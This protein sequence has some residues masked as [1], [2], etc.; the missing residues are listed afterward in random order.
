MS[1][2]YI[3]WFF[4]NHSFISWSSLSYVAGDSAN[5]DSILNRQ[6]VIWLDIL[7]DIEEIGSLLLLIPKDAD[8]NWEFCWV[9]NEASSVWFEFI[10]LKLGF[11]L[12]VSLWPQSLAIVLENISFRLLWLVSEICCWFLENL[13]LKFVFRLTLAF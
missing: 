11:E 12:T 5:L 1:I 4:F 3:Y 13:F 6:L 8:I 2:Y 10:M 7:F 9:S